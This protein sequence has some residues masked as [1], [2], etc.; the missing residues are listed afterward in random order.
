[1][2]HVYQGLWRRWYPAAVQHPGPF[3][4]VCVSAKRTRPAPLGRLQRQ[5]LDDQRCD[6]SFQPWRT[7][8]RLEAT[9]T[10]THTASQGAVWGESNLPRLTL[11]ECVPLEQS[12]PSGCFRSGSASGRGSWPC[13]ETAW[14]SSSYGCDGSERRTW[15]PL[16]LPRLCHTDQQQSDQQLQTIKE[17]KK[18]CTGNKRSNT[19][20]TQL[21]AS[22]PVRHVCIVKKGMAWR[23]HPRSLPGWR[24]CRP[25]WQCE[26][27]SCQKTLHPW[28][29]E[30]TAKSER[31]AKNSSWKTVLKWNKGPDT[32]V[33][34]CGIIPLWLYC[35]F[36]PLGWLFHRWCGQQHPWVA[37]SF[38]ASPWET[39]NRTLWWL[40]TVNLLI[41]RLN[42]ND[43]VWIKVKWKPTWGLI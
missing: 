6:P 3:W 25:W 37:P 7:R 5:Q 8:P 21:Y 23:I 20:L 10:H 41:R 11:Q 42:L 16:L 18:I 15:T 26:L 31:G 24:R 17:D 22:S 13:W 33:F 2:K 43:C 14:S 1:M 32:S 28:Q 34:L 39:P 9:H 4:R 30:M 38:A 36:W 27:G 12:E 29:P 40:V 19:G 35:W